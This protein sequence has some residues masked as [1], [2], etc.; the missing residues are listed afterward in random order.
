[1]L[2][3]VFCVHPGVLYLLSARCDCDDVCECVFKSFPNLLWVLV[4]SSNYN[5]YMCVCDVVCVRAGRA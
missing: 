1:M 4:V 5:I 3:F 2:I